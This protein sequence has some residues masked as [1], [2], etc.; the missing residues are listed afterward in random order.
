MYQLII[1]VISIFP[2][3]GYLSVSQPQKSSP[4]RVMSELQYY[5]PG[6]QIYYW[7]GDAFGI[8]GAQEAGHDVL[9]YM[10]S[11]AKVTDALLNGK[12]SKYPAKNEILDR[13]LSAAPEY[14]A[15]QREA[16]Q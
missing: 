4:N 6:K 14:Y 11:E 15:R 2:I 16:N 13:E 3:G 12:R 9:L 7:F 8:T 1:C 5:S 10:G